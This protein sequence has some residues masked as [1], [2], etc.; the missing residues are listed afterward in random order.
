MCFFLIPIITH[1]CQCFCECRACWSIPPA[2]FLLF[3]MIQPHF[4]T[5][6]FHSTSFNF[7]FRVAH[8]LFSLL[9]GRPHLCVCVCS[10]T[11]V[12]LFVT[13]QIVAHQA[14]LSM[15]FPRPEY[16][17]RLLFLTS[18]DPPYPEIEPVS[19][20]SCIGRQI[21]YHCEL[22]HFAVFGWNITLWARS[23]LIVPLGT[24]VFLFLPRT[25][26]I[27]CMYDWFFFLMYHLPLPS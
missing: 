2:T 11:H 8:M 13:P 16:W 17:S 23:S 3:G 24:L 1:Y 9:D 21:L 14:S 15:V 6:N 7:Q 26:W 19:C 4:L 27:L 10:V 22:L 18:G 25:E 20:I 12:W 5:F